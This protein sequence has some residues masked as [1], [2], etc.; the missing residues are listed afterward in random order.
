MSTWMSSMLLT[1]WHFKQKFQ[2]CNHTLECFK[3]SRTVQNPLPKLILTDVHLPKS[4]KSSYALQ[5]NTYKFISI[6]TNHCKHYN[7]S[8]FT[9]KHF[10]ECMGNPTTKTIHLTTKQWNATKQSRHDLSTIRSL[11]LLI[12]RPVES[13]PSPANSKFSYNV[14]R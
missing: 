4:G 14:Q 13:S 12:P 3:K 9:L 10:W 6:F 8:N 1:G 11:E 7:T 5:T 2:T